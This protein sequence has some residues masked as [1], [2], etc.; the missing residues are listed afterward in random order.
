M[1]DEL[2]SPARS[3]VALDA[4]K[5]NKGSSYADGTFCETKI[6]LHAD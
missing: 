1:H 2:F 4:L 6:Q 3:S 5:I